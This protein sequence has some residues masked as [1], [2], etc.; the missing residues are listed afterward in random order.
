MAIETIL[1]FHLC[2]NSDH[3]LIRDKHKRSLH[4]HVYCKMELVMHNSKD[5]HT[6]YYLNIVDI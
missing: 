6:V 4:I 1:R 2:V 5:F 3:A